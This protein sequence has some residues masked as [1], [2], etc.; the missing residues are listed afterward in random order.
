[1]PYPD[2]TH[3]QCPK[4]SFYFNTGISVHPWESRE[5]L[6][7]TVYVQTIAGMYHQRSV[8]KKN[9]IV[10][11]SCHFKY[12]F[13]TDKFILDFIRTINNLINKEKLT[14]GMHTLYMLFRVK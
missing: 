5:Q 4:S 6:F 11:L 14:R 12:M 9:Y 1:M 2:Y 3:L 13:Q 8:L 10:E 7:L